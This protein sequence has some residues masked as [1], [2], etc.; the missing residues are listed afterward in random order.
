MGRRFS[1]GEIIGVR[2]GD[3][4][5]STPYYAYGVLPSSQ[6]VPGQLAPIS[7][8]P[9][10]GL[11]ILQKFTRYQSIRAIFVRKF[12]S[13]SANSSAVNIGVT[14]P[15]RN[16]E[17]HHQRMNLLSRRS[18]P[19]WDLTLVWIS[20]WMLYHVMSGARRPGCS[21]LA[22]KSM[23]IDTYQANWFARQQIGFCST[24]IMRGITM[25]R[26]ETDV[27]HLSARHNPPHHVGV[28][29]HGGVQFL[30]SK[31][32]IIVRCLD[33]D[34]GMRR[35]SCPQKGVGVEFTVER[36]RTLWEGRRVTGGGNSSR[37]EPTATE[38][39]CGG[40]PDRT[41]EPWLACV[42]HVV[43]FPAGRL[44]NWRRNSTYFTASIMIIC[45]DGS[46]PNTTHTSRVQT[47]AGRSQGCLRLRKQCRT[48]GHGIP[49]RSV[50]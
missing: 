15:L 38:F 16:H 6:Q 33:L 25:D 12:Y 32:K 29:E 31:H 46:T 34:T 37:L 36:Y 3:C 4:L 27:R 35:R 47:Q 13:P 18:C 11:M 43:T 49:N 28:R 42:L 48:G 24:Q 1:A 14:H 7:T 22:Y 2:K 9:G 10:V 5:A 39:R 30:Q 19:R 45:T 17:H 20:N 26:P 50:R 8:I 44:Q 23:T 41:D 21:F 40:S